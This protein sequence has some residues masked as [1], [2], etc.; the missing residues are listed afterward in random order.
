MMARLFSGKNVKIGNMTLGLKPGV[1]VMPLLC[2][3]FSGNISGIPM[4]EG[5]MAQNMNQSGMMMNGNSE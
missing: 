4:M 2:M 5:M 3:S 1:M